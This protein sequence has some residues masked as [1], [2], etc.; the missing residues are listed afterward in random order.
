MFA[1]LGLMCANFIITTYASKLFEDSGSHLSPNASAIIL[2]VVQLAGT[3]LAIKFVESLGRKS[4]L[5][6]SLAGSTVGTLTLAIYSLSKSFAY[7]VSAF[8]WVPIA[9]MTFVI[10]ISSVGIVPL[11]PMCTVEALPKYVRS[12]GLTIGMFTMNVTAFLLAWA[13]PI[14]LDAIQL[15]GCMLIFSV[16]CAFGIIYVVFC[17]DETKGKQLDALTEEKFVSVVGKL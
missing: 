11:G 6:L 2:A 15:H 14:L 4:L 9:S 12:I 1:I 10:F 8:A 16:S 13:F 3:L 17:V 7:D 5:I